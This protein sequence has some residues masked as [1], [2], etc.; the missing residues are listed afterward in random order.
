MKNLICIVALLLPFVMA[1]S[2][3]DE[4]VPS[5][6]GTVITVE[7]NQSRTSLSESIDGKRTVSWSAGDRIAAN[8][9]VSGEAQI[10]AEQPGVA[11]FAFAGEIGY[12]RNILY[13]ASFYNDATSVILPR[14]QDYAE[15]TVATNTL[16][17]ATTV[18]ALGD[19]TKLHHLAAVVHLQLK[20]EA[21]PRN[22]AIRKV[23]IRGRA[24]EQMS[25]KFL[26]DYDAVQLTPTVVI[27]AGEKADNVLA[28]VAGTRVF[29]ELSTDNITDLFVV[30]PAQKYAEGFTVRVINE[31]GHY[32]DKAKTSGV[33]L[34]NGEI[35]KLPPFEYI[36]TGTIINV[37]L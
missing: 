1:C 13:P 16:P 21:T 11:S 20:A 17:M 3:N 30:V 36:P 4:A 6:E 8:G 23:E 26:I 12:P 18:N 2:S 31:Y 28:L 15:E 33:T 35:Y 27:P 5:Q 10:S 25:G 22:N 37:E 19:A 7:L 9:E 29:T 32:M 34:S 14:V 24:N